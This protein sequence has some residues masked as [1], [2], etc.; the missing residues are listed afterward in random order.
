MRGQ[1]GWGQGGCCYV[2]LFSTPTCTNKCTLCPRV[3]DGSVLATVPGELPILSHHPLHWGQ[4]GGR[5][6][7]F[8]A[9]SAK[10][11]SVGPLLHTRACVPPPIISTKKNCQFNY[12]LIMFLQ[13]WLTDS[14][15]WSLRHSLKVNVWEDQRSG[16]EFQL[17][18][19]KKKTKQHKNSIDVANQNVDIPVVEHE[20]SMLNLHNY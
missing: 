1:N 14:R 13:S 7:I 6:S 10:Q 9:F 3:T 5:H 17:P 19:S 15:I 2:T 18:P 12:R 8:S 16:V 11:K 4:L 20:E